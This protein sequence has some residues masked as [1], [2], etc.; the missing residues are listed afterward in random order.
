MSF[1]G[2]QSLSCVAGGRV[3][4]VLDLQIQAAAPFMCLS[5]SSIIDTSQ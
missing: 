4:T 1:N 5:L 2:I 3:V